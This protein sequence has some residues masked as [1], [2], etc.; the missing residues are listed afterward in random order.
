MSSK[1]AAVGLTMMIS[2]CGDSAPSASPPADYTCDHSWDTSCRYT[3]DVQIHSGT[4]IDAS[5]FDTAQGWGTLGAFR[6]LS[7]TVTVSDGLSADTTTC[8]FTASWDI[9]TEMVGTDA[10]LTSDPTVNFEA[11][12]PITCAWFFPAS[13]TY[14]DTAGRYTVSVQ[15]GHWSA[16]IGAWAPEEP[17]SQEWL[18]TA[19]SSST[20]G[21]NASLNEPV[22][23]YASSWTLPMAAPPASVLDA[24]C[25]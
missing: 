25:R 7:G 16:M 6:N 21:A 13:G 1:L 5:L 9:G 4:L 24:T 19:A 14:D 11:G 3:A 17:Y 23:V 15:E 10:A 18:T 12:C 22:A 8:N 2:T 20:Y